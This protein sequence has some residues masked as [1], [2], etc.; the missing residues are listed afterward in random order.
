M[1][2]TLEKLN[3]PFPPTPTEIAVVEKAHEMT[4]QPG[5]TARVHF[6]LNLLEGK[7][8]HIARDR[9]YARMA[10]DFAKSVDAAAIMFW[11][12]PAAGNAGNL[13][14]NVELKPDNA[15]PPAQNTPAPS[16]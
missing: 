10:I 1:G 2:C 6:P 9:S 13:A 14:L 3:I 7:A 8:F 15:L 5:K 11:V 12:P 16:A 4:I